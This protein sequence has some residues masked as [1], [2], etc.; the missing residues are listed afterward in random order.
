MIFC[1]KKKINAHAH[2]HAHAH[3]HAHTH[4]HTH[5]HAHAHLHTHTHTHP[6]KPRS[7]T[8]SPSITKSC[9]IFTDRALLS[10]LFEYSQPVVNVSVHL[11]LPNSIGHW[12]LD[13]DGA[14]RVCGVRGVYG[15]G[16]VGAVNMCSWR[17]KS[18]KLDSCRRVE[19]RWGWWQAHQCCAHR[20]CA[21]LQ[22][23]HLL[24]VSHRYLMPPAGSVCLPHLQPPS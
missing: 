21:G 23:G 10:E 13:G 20:R 2:A 22:R 16:E 1:Y 4:T 8:K 14:E 18:I 12:H 3:T 9:G 11:G 6:H 17:Y 7:A 19:R 5:T 24:W 15:Q